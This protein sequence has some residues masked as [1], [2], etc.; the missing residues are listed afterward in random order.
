MTYSYL[1]LEG[2]P[3]DFLRRFL[4][5]R[6]TLDTDRFVSAVVRDYYALWIR[7]SIRLFQQLSH[8]ILQS[9]T[10]QDRSL[11]V[12]PLP[13][14][15]ATTHGISF[16]FFSWGYLDVS[17]HPVSRYMAMY[18]PCNSQAFTLARFPHSDISRSML[19]CSSLKLF[20]ACRVL[21]R[22]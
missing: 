17:V 20:A 13:L 16:D 9:I 15:L 14:S 1:G 22:R 2:G 21:H 19:M 3:P 18:S 10:P 11:T 8:S 12:W 5:S 6:S 4:V 7:L